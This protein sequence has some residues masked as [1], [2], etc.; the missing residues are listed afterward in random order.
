MHATS[1]QQAH[2]VDWVPRQGDELA[3]QNAAPEPL[4]ARVHNVD[5][6]GQHCRGSLRC[7]QSQRPDCA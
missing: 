5:E 2:R 1:Q 3:A 7:K 4:H 6:V